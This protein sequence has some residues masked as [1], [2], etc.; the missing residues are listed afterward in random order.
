MIRRSRRIRAGPL[1]RRLAE[2]IVDSNDE[3]F[4]GHRFVKDAHK[5]IAVQRSGV[6]AADNHD[7]DVACGCMG[8]QFRLHITSTESRQL[9]I[10]DH[11]IWRIRFDATQRVDPVLDIDDGVAADP[12]YLTIERPKFWIIFY[13]QDDLRPG[14]PRII[15]GGRMSGKAEARRALS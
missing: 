3:P 8:C 9:D 6:G 5:R 12:Q 14:H 4:G 15:G 1:F 7:R 13:H 10:Q 2:T 11:Q